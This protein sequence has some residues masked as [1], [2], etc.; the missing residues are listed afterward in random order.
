MLGIDTMSGL[1]SGTHVIN[2]SQRAALQ[3]IILA[4][5]A[6][7]NVVVETEHF[8]GTICVPIIT[9]DGTSAF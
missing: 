7:A 4:A 6:A 8:M 3:D 5:T 2:G 9:I 1:S